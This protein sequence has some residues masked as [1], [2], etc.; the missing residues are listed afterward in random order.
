MTN[1]NEQISADLFPMIPRQRPSVVI[2]PLPNA[3]FEV[4]CREIQWWYGIPEVGYKSVIASYE[5]ETG[6]INV[7]TTAH[8]LCLASIHR[9]ACVKIKMTDYTIKKG[10]Q[11]NISYYYCAM[12]DKEVG[13]VAVCEYEEGIETL[14]TTKDQLFE[15]N[16]AKSWEHD[17]QR[18][19]RVSGRF[20]RVGDNIYETTDDSTDNGEGFYTVQIGE[21]THECIRLLEID[22]KADEGSEMNEVYLN[23]DG[24][25]VYRRQHRGMRMGY[26]GVPPNVRFPTAQIITIDGCKYVQCNCMETIHDDITNTGLRFD[27][28]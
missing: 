23:R 8:S 22:E 25:S 6:N 17:N 12:D 26:N 11:P 14:I 13:W 21:H 4:D 20:R 5:M 3:N 1:T 27:M 18:R 28:P 19:K 2:T 24:R 15:W 9:V 10:W 7:I 16:W